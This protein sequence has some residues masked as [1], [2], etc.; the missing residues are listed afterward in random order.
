MKY[1]LLFVFCCIRFN[2]FSS[3]PNWLQFG[4]SS[5]ILCMKS[6]GNEVWCGTPA[7]I[8]I[9][10]KTDH[11]V[12]YLK[13]SDGALC[14][15]YVNDILTDSSGNIWVSSFGGLS[16]WNGSEWTRFYLST[17]N[18]TMQYSSI[19]I[20]KNG[21]IWG[22]GSG[23]F[24]SADS[25]GINV[26]ERDYVI[27]GHMEFGPMAITA[28]T[29]G[30]IYI[31]TQDYGLLTYNGSTWTEM[32]I[33]NSTLIS[34]Y[35]IEVKCD[36]NNKIWFILQTNNS[37]PVYY[38][39]SYDSSG[40][41]LF[42]PNVLNPNFEPIRMYIDKQNNKYFYDYNA[43]GTCGLFIYNDT[44]W[45]QVDYSSGQ[46]AS[47]YIRG[48]EIDDEGT[49]FTFSHWCLYCDYDKA[50]QISAWDSTSFNETN[51]AETKLNNIRSILK[52]GNGNIYALGN[53]NVFKF[54]NYSW[55][56]IS[57]PPNVMV[58]M[59]SDGAVID[60]N[61]NLLMIKYSSSIFA[62]Y[63]GQNWSVIN[64]PFIYPSQIKV[65]KY[66]NVWISGTNPTSGDKSLFKYNWST[67]TRFDQ[68]NS[69]IQSMWAMSFDIDNSG[70]V[71]FSERSST[72]PLQFNVC[73]YDGSTWTS[74]DSTSSPFIHYG[75]F[76][77][78]PSGRIFYKMTSNYNPYQTDKYYEYDGSSLHYD[79]LLS[80]FWINGARHLEEDHEGNI[81]FDP[82]MDYGLFLL[83]DT[84]I[85][86]S[87]TLNES[88]LPA[89]NLAPMVLDGN[90]IW[91]TDYTNVYVYSEDGISPFE[92]SSYRKFKGLIFYD[93]N[94]NGIRDSIEQPVNGMQVIMLPD[95]NT[96][97]TNAN[98]EYFFYVS[99]SLAHTV[100]FIPPYGWLMTTDSSVYHCMQDSLD[101]DSL[102]FGINTDLTIINHI[103]GTLTSGILRCNGSTNF[104]PSV[105]NEGTLPADITVD[106]Y[107]DPQS[108]FSGSF[109]GPVT[110]TGN[111][112]QYNFFDVLPLETKYILAYIRMPST[113]GL[114]TTFS[115]VASSPNADSVFNVISG[116][117][118]CSSD[119]NDKTAI[120]AGVDNA[121][122]T[123]INDSIEYLIRFENVGSDTAFRVMIMDSI[124]TSILDMN[125]L[126]FV[127]SSHPC[128]MNADHSGFVRFV[129]DPIELPYK[130]I[131]PSG[132]E[133][134]VRFSIYPRTDI[135]PGTVINNKASIVFDYNAA[136]ITNETMNTLVTV[137]PTS[138]SELD[139]N[140]DL[141]IYP[142]P[143]TNKLF[144]RSIFD[145]KGFVVYNSLGGKVMKGEC[146]GTMKDV[147]ISNLSSGMYFLEVIG[148]ENSSKKIFIKH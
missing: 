134:Y 133:G 29:S 35:I 37:N 112:L 28:D 61:N 103:S 110:I 25:T 106:F 109:P 71:W 111:H 82:G 12:R 66:N 116:P 73:S 74:Y 68:S 56:D 83:N 26:I 81:W 58:P 42:Q 145:L 16:R 119:P 20:D 49:V 40:L 135:T 17:A 62:K 80:S 104:W 91:L 99:D 90:N 143:A 70:R 105:T 126:R 21:T 39:Y 18:D 59:Y 129:F 142:V 139:I 6:I 115:L 128:V 75:V 102:D 4:G 10:N 9:Y 131:D 147:D 32:N 144:I 15:T 65:D 140:N 122:Y 96:T 85:I 63:D 33:S 76:E 136:V 48:L 146:S 69:P 41:T 117:I 54:I 72:G 11:T 77:T 114:Q 89:L 120:P 148:D 132:S 67:F 98:G 47:P 53:Y 92:E 2:S 13:K 34:N 125:T 24:F 107:I 138:V 137:I 43:A 30:N 19:C 22:I 36:L 7:G 100:K 1:L 5:S 51:L 50:P 127:A 27:N 46:F 113:A 23:Y 8:S 3:D 31:A 93:Q 141:V 130:N 45:R 124:D 38:I 87:I 121:H 88:S 86:K 60:H 14:G 79:S 108:T 118:V 78:L 57:P 123:L 97:A 95:S 55:V 84:G 94:Q 64:L 44:T 52:D 101:Y